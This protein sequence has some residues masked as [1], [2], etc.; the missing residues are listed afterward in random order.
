VD[1]AKI[2]DA[3]HKALGEPTIGPIAD[4]LPLIDAAISRAMAGEPE[5]TS[6]RV[7]EAAEK[8]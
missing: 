5:T 4:A 2:I 1:A 7:V 6:T 3:V 8:R